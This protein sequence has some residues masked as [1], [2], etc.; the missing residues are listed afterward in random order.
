[1]WKPVVDLQGLFNEV[2]DRAGYDYVIDYSVEAVPS[3]S[4]KDKVWASE[5]LQQKGLR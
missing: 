5:M 4:E 1:M 3:L 2:Y